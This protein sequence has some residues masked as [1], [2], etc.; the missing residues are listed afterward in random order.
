MT[1]DDPDADHVR[2]GSDTDET[3]PKKPRPRS[4]GPQKVLTA[5]GMTDPW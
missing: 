3:L 5:L 1:P 2:S 4:P